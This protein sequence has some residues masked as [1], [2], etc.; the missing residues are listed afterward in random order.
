MH[1]T[2]VLVEPQYGVA[3]VAAQSV[4]TTQPTQVSF[5]RSHTGLPGIA[6][7]S[8]LVT[9]STQVFD[10]SLQTGFEAGQYAPDVHCT[11]AFDPAQAGVGAAHSLSFWHAT[12]TFVEVSQ[13][14]VDAPQ[15]PEQGNCGV[16]AAPAMPAPAKPPPSPAPAVL[17]AVP[18][19]APPVSWLD[20]PPVETPP[21]PDEPAA[22]LQS[23]RASQS[24]FLSVQLAAAAIAA[25]S[26]RIDANAG[27]WDL[28]FVVTVIGA[29]KSGA[30]SGA[31]REPGGGGAPIGALLL[32]IVQPL[33]DRRTASSQPTPNWAKARTT[34]GNDATLVAREREALC[35]SIAAGVGAP[36]R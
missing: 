18:P 22:A 20:C 1:P 23:P 16:P 35:L 36:R 8:E 26:S 12:Q 15:V 31:L 6:A 4:F 34:D 30:R 7:Q 29:S 11:Q 9:H 2:H 24:S 33:L 13:M 3:G 21:R 27:D 14:G 5:D 10:S 17:A 32:E 28:S 25:A 19:L